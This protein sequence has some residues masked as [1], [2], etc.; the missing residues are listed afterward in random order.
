[1]GFIKIIKT[2]VRRRISETFPLSVLSRKTLLKT[3]CFWRV[4]CVMLHV[5][6]PTV[7]AKI[8]SCNRHMCVSFEYEWS[9]FKIPS[10]LF[11]RHSILTEM[12]DTRQRE[13]VTSEREHITCAGT[14]VPSWN[15]Q[16]VRQVKLNCKIFLYLPKFSFMMNLWVR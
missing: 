1:M 5:S 11:R 12:L 14:S 9:K 4:S 2:F 16:H 15:A 8:Y 7:C 10:V 6:I 13:D 3:D